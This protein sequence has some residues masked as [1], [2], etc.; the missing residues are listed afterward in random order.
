MIKIEKLNIEYEECLI[1]DGRILIPDG[2]M[3]VISGKSGVGKTSILYRLGLI[4]VSN[5]YIYTM[6]DK[7]INLSD[8]KLVS[9]VQQNDI[10]FLFQDGTMIESLTVKE[11]IILSAQTAGSDIKDNEIIEL[12]QKVQLTKD[13]L[14]LYPLKLS[15]GERQRASLA[16]I[17]AKKSKYI[18]ADEP[19][20]SL[21]KEN[22][23]IIINLLQ[24]LKKKGYSIIV[25]THS[26][27]VIKEADIVYSI[28][29]KK[30][31]CEQSN[32]EIEDYYKEVKEFSTTDIGG[33][34]LNKKKIFWYALH[35][36]KKGRILNCI[37]I[38]FCAIAISGFAVTNNII[39][40][41]MQMQEQLLNRLSDREI[42]AVNLSSSATD[43][44]V[45]DSDGNP[46]IDDEL[47]TQI[48]QMDGVDKVYN[49][50]EWKSFNLTNSEITL[51][52][53]INVIKDSSINSTYTYSLENSNLDYYVALPYYEEQNYENQVMFQFG[54][55][56]SDG[57][58]I[59]YD[60]AQELGVLEYKGENLILELDI[61]VPVYK[62]I[63]T[64]DG[65]EYSQ[66]LV[67]FVTIKININGILDRNVKN[68]YTID[69]NSIIY[70]PY[71]YMNMM[72]QNCTWSG[73]ISSYDAE[74]LH[75]WGP[76]AIVVYADS[77]KSV[78]I[79]KGKVN[80]I[81]PNIVTRYAYQDTEVIEQ[82]VQGFKSIANTLL[83][84]VL[85]IIFSLMC[86]IYLS[87]TIGRKHEYAILKTN[88]FTCI[89]LS[90]ITALESI[91][92]AVKIVS[93]SLILSYGI[94]SILCMLILGSYN[95]IGIKIVV[96]VV[97]L[98]FLFVFIPSLFSAIYIHG[99]KV[100]KIIRN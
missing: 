92:Q 57:A 30:I 20:A 4:S 13:K 55:I 94:T 26:D 63:C 98:S 70:L 65:I 29:D 47:I 38:L 1:K 7:V 44:L 8:K 54:K 60:L 56:K 66:D 49:M 25:S 12:L 2:C 40:Y 34:K 100:E 75:K 11:N 90:K 67:E 43:N 97:L 15:S 5:D 87:T 14:D 69:G 28:I 79:L 48:S 91:I 85:C 21:D 88:G 16:M 23:Q 33:Y 36:K 52:G 77:Y 81:T 80:S 93:I 50:I 78:E 82:T 22:A 18:I 86:A 61:G 71:D 73:D 76:S 19:T 84:I 10:G 68:S 31:V 24:E 39:D 35:S 27:E 62:Y 3:V 83:I 59:S 51:E 89:E 41:L 17:L 37:L 96:Y 64:D 74:N 99:L 32:I 72:M 6:D 53:D 42:Y 58:Y 9:S 45:L 46:V 95:I